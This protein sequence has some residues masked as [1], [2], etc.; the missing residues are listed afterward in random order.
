[1]AYDP[2]HPSVGGQGPWRR[3]G[4]WVLKRP[5]AA[6]ITTVA[7]FIAGAFGLLAY[8]VDYSTTSFF[9]HSVEAVEGFDVLESSFPAGTLAPTTVLVESE[10]GP[11]TPA[12]IAEVENRLRSVNGVATA[13]DTGVRSTNGQIGE[14]DA[15]LSSDPLDKSGLNVVPR[16]RDALA[17]LPNGV[18]AL[19]GGTSAINYDVD[20]ANQRDIEIIVPLALLVMAVILAIL[21][22]ALVAP[23]VLLLSVVLSFACSL[24]ISILIIR[25]VVG[26]AGFDSSIPLFAFIFLVAL[27]IDYTIFLMARVRE[28]ART[29]GTREGMLRALAA[30]GGVIT[31]AGII[32][33]GTFSVLMTLPVSFT[34]DLGLMVALGILLDTFIVRTIMVPA[35]VEVI[36]DKIWWP[37]TARAGG[38]LREETGEHPGARARRGGLA[39]LPDRFA[40]LREGRHALAEV[41]RA[42]A[43]LAQLDQLALLLRCEA[44]VGVERVDCVLVAAHR[45]RRVGRDLRR[46]LHRGGLEVAVVGDLIDQAELLSPLRRHVVA[47]QEELL[48]SRHADRVDEP[49]QAGVAVDQAELR[50][51]HAELGAAR[52]DAQVAAQCELESAAESVAVDRAEDR[53]RMRRDRVESAR[54]GMGDEGLGLGLELVLGESADVV[55]RREDASGAGEDHATH[56]DAPVEGGHDLG[57]AVQ[58]LVVERVPRIRPVQ[59]QPGDRLSWM[60]E[61]EL[62]SR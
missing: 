18:T 41:L 53:P 42:E 62:P 13:T 29:H 28:E 38:R 1:M 11:V 14:V 30:T 61:K 5:V 46:E 21:L 19:V 37:S 10:S 32:L 3:F 35:A 15:V 52:A 33:A 25:Y 45:E 24:G 57:D 27:G 2:Q 7:L 23:L 55:A 6:L 8:K 47:G 59:G 9:K 20:Q 43:G 48:G 26:D 16:M 31:S 60:V 34:F 58:R 54:E 17:D 44:G 50:G 39:P 22:Q 51:G 12:D 56:L 49:L 4:D 40:L 36:G